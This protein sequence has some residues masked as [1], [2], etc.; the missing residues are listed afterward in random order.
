MKSPLISLTFA[1]L[2]IGGCATQSMLTVLSQPDGAY[3]T[4]QTSGKQLGMAPTRIAYDAKKLAMHKDAQGCYLVYG[5]E[6][7]WVSGARTVSQDKIKLCGSDTGNYTYTLVRPD[8]DGLDKDLT[9]AV[10]VETMRAQQRQARATEDAMYMQ[11]LNS[12]KQ[13]NCTSTN[14]G[15]YVSTSCN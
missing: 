13:V 14:I 9:F 5:F 2:L 15:G 8:F 11:M 1:T 10:Q 12:T 7:K 6:A 3:I 4:E